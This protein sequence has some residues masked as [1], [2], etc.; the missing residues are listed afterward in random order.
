MIDIKGND[1][2]YAMLY[3]KSSEHDYGASNKK[4]KIGSKKRDCPAAIYLREV[5][6]FPEYKV[7]VMLLFVNKTSRYH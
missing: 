5:I 6:A 3:F 1:A 7:N 4:M 2:K